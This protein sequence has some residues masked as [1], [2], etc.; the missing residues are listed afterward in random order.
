MFVY[1]RGTRIDD[2]LVVLVEAMD[3]PIADEQAIAEGVGTVFVDRC[4]TPLLVG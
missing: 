1:D 3:A 2:K 4:A